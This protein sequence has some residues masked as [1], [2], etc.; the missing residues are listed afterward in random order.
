MIG[1]EEVLAKVGAN[2]VCGT[3]VRILR[4]EKNGLSTSDPSSA[5]SWQVRAIPDHEER[6]RATRG[7]R[8][9]G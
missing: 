1:P 5:S 7:K 9:P 4:G 6:Q 3:D 2:T 8:S